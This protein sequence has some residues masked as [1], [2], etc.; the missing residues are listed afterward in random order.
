MPRLTY[1][2]KLPSPEQLQKDLL[3]AK[4][5]TNPV[6]DLLDM[7]QKLQHYEQKYSL[8]SAEFYQQYQA[9]V[10][11]DELQHCIAWAAAY[12]I[13]RKTKRKLEAALMRSAV[14]PDDLTV[15][16]TVTHEVA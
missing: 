14:R 4:A 11:N 7:W 15:S 16:R 12:E 3:D 2:G 10:L 8:S 1:T 9:G 13:F 5:Q 6:D